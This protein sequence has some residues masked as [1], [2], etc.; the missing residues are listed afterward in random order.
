LIPLRDIL[1]DV[2]K[3]H[4]KLRY[5]D[6]PANEWMA[7]FAEVLSY[8]TLDIGITV[9]EYCHTKIDK[10]YRMRYYEN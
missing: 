10:H 8:H 3:N 7:Y 4:N 6:I 9:C 1:K 5:S 2:L